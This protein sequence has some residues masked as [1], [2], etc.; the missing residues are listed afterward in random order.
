MSDAEFMREQRKH[1]R[2]MTDEKQSEL[3]EEATEI[4][5]L[6]TQAVMAPGRRHEC[7]AKDQDNNIASLNPGDIGPAR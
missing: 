5:A 7:K 6:V 2:V 4:R 1:G 3:D